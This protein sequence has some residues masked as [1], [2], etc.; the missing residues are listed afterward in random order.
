M[1]LVENEM[2]SSERHPRDRA[3]TRRR[4]I[5]AVGRLLARQGFQGVGVNAIAR[6]SGCDKVLIYRYFGGVQELLR[7]YA[8][9]G[10]FWPTVQHLIGDAP[11]AT[12]NAELA[13]R[14][15]GG[16]LRW[17]R[18]H[19]L[20]QEILRWELLERNELTEC[21]TRYREEF[22]RQLME[23]FAPEPGLDLEAVGSLLAAGITYL[24]L[25]SKPADVYNGLRLDSEQ[26]WARVEAA[27]ESLIHFG[28]Q[29][30]GKPA[31]VLS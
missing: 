26:D 7:A 13:R 16:L 25:R 14:A 6:E 31:P 28:L 4:I 3:R 19:P 27:L 29:G 24:V 22:G 9:E 1:S 17:L 23:A 30:S 10:D 11:P 20:T 21:L 8:A 5:E 18:R 15:L 2:A 12:P